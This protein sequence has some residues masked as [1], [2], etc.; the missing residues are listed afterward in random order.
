MK[1]LKIGYLAIISFFI[2]SLFWLPANLSSEEAVKG[3]L[4]GFVYAQDGTTPLEGAIVKAKNIASGIVYE[5]DISDQYGAYRINDVERGIYIIGVETTIGD[6]N[7][8]DLVGLR[9]KANETAKLSLS[10][11]SYK[12]KLASAIQEVNEELKESGEALIGRVVEYNSSTRMA[13]VAVTRGLLRVNDRIHTRGQV[14]DFYQDLHI[15]RKEG[16]PIDVIFPLENAT[17]G[18]NKKAVPNDGI[19]VVK[20]RKALPLYLVPVGVAAIVAGS[21]SIIKGVAKV[22]DEPVAAS[23]FKK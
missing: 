5:S 11:R 14:T 1:A 4:I 20:K 2:L 23:P 7:I 21:S 12:Q 6:F 18:L 8:D 15:L 9:I 13:K 3:N 22:Q 17:I 10:L 16:N 19:Y